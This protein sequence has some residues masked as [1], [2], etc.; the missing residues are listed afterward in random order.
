MKFGLFPGLGV[1]GTLLFF[2]TSQGVSASSSLIL[3]EVSIAGESANDEYI[4]LYNT[5]DSPLDISSYQLRKRTASGSESSIKVFP[6]NSFIPARGFFLWANSQGIYQEPLADTETSA[7]LASNNSVGLFSSSGADGILIDSIA[8]G[9]GSPFTTTTPPL[10]N[11]EKNTSLARDTTTLAWTTTPVLSPTNT[12]GQTWTAPEPDPPPLSPSNIQVRFSE[13]FPDPEGDE[14]SEEFIELW[15]GAS[16]VD[17]SGFVIRDNSKTG[18][19]TFPM[20]TILPENS[21]FVLKRAISKIAL[22][23][24]DETLSL[25]DT[26]G[27]LI[28]KIGRAHV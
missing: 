5:S 8:W 21:Y 17:L 7:S 4:E 16:A 28:D 13:I 22:N 14:S 3:S 18:S 9:T 6:K 11:P 20:S 12:E 26:A 25:F 19:Y 1:L 23:N 27:L 24:T 15:N 2:L 10:A